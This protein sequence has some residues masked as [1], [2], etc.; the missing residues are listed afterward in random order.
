MTKKDYEL[1]ASVYRSEMEFYE[2]YGEDEIEPKAIIA[3]NAYQMASAL[4]S[5]NPK[6]DR[7]KFLQACGVTE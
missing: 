5:I 6:F 4:A 1:I 7:D 3:S 2:D